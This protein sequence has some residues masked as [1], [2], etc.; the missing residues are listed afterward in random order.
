MRKVWVL[1]HR[2]EHKF[3]ATK[4]SDALNQFSASTGEDCFTVGHLA[5]LLETGEWAIGQESNLI[6]MRARIRGCLCGWRE[7]EPVICSASDDKEHSETAPDTLAYTYGRTVE[8]E[9]G[10]KVSEVRWQ[11]HY[12][13]GIMVGGNY[14]HISGRRG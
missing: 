12:G 10:I 4:L 8:Q 5:E 6:E 11:H 2:G 13:D 1:R 9:R 14:V 7:I 3:S